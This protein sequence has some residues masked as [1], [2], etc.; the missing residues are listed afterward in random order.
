ML[1]LRADTCPDCGELLS[2]SL[3]VDGRPDPQYS[4]HYAICMGCVAKERGQRVQDARDA[5]V[6][7]SGGMVFRAARKWLLKQIGG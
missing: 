5:P 7:K 6:E 3:H 1:D 4:S 2:E